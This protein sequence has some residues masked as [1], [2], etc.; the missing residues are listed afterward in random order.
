MRRFTILAFVSLLLLHNLTAQ[1]AATTS[2]PNLIRYSGTFNEV[3]S[4][5]SVKP[6]TVGV[7]FAIYKQQEGGAPI[8]QEAQNVTL[9]ASG[10]YSVLLGSTTSTGLPDDLFS[11]QEERWLGVQVQGQDEQTRV[12]LVSVPYAFKAHEADTLGGLPSSAFVKLPSADAVAGSAS[13]TTANA[14]TTSAGTNS[15][16]QSGKTRTPAQT[17]GFIPVWDGT[18]DVSS[19]L[20]QNAVGAGATVVNDA[21]NFNLFNASRTYQIG[22][23][24]VLSIFG[25]DNLL[26]G[27]GAGP[28]NTGQDNT[29][30]GYLAGNANTSAS[31][32][33]AIGSEAGQLKQTGDGNA[34]AGYRAGYRNHAGSLNAFFGAEAGHYNNGSNNVLVGYA[35]DFGPL[36]YAGNTGDN[37]TIVGFEA[38]FVNVASNNS[39]FGYQS[40]HSNTKG[41]GNSFFG[42]QSGYNNTTAINLEGSRESDNSFFGYQAGFNVN[43]GFYNAYFGY[44]A[45]YT[46]DGLYNAYFGYRA[47]SGGNESVAVGVLAGATDTGFANTMVGGRAG[48]ESNGGS[49]NTFVGHEAGFDNYGSTWNNNTYIGAE[50]GYYLAGNNNSV[51]GENAGSNLNGNNDLYLGYF[52]SFNLILGGDNN[53]YVGS[54]GCLGTC[55]QESNAIRIGNQN[56]SSY[57]TQTDAYMAGV[58]LSTADSPNQP[59]CVDANGKLFSVASGCDTGS[60]RH[61]KD[62]IADMGDS[63]NKLFQL[64]PVTFFYKPGYDDGSHQV[65][66][67]LIAEEVAQVYPEMVAFDKDG[68]PSGLR[69]QMLAPMLLNELQKQHSVVM[70]QRQ[71][72]ETLK[73]QL[74]Q[75]NA[76]LQL[77]NASLE[78]RLQK[79][80]SFVETQTKSASGVAPAATVNGGVQ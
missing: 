43:Q 57:P 56:D 72:I 75:Q 59:V 35:A 3:Q 2:V 60:S 4:A 49:L 71:E 40:G 10:Q 58:W 76:S 38:G 19:A 28:V 54:R 61:I 65:Q 27:P 47:G 18:M 78:Q 46:G 6:A 55:F 1:Q 77:K 16:K 53:I 70:T 32:N 69:Y 41:A 7:T 24:P 17:A 21:V 63:T 33:T 30:A 51:V 42:Y 15:G 31:R 80:E 36:A 22:G 5:S 64:R 11:Q 26:L 39:F 37:N 66:Y 52:A 74:Q 34:L 50:T 48:L 25:V 12:M 45:G 9:D 14:S 20:S 62:Q 29:F 67:G 79:L 44:Q 23:S 73:L 68:Q 13:A 8:W